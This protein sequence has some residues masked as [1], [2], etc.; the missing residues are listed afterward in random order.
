MVQ[1]NA[2]NYIKESIMMEHVDV[3]TRNRNVTGICVHF[4]KLFVNVVS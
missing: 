4:E 1:N 2:R 3:K